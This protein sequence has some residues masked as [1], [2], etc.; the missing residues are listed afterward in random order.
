MFGS[1][2]GTAMGFAQ[3]LGK[4]ARKKNIKA[5]VV[6]LEEFQPADMLS[7][8]SEV[9]VFV[10]ATFGQGEGTDNAK[11]FFEWLKAN[12]REDDKSRFSPLRFAVFGLGMSQTYPARYQAAAK[13]VEKRMLELGAQEI[14]ERGEGDDNGD[15]ETNFEEWVD[16]LFPKLQELDDTSPA[17]E[18]KDVGAR[19]ATATAVEEEK[20]FSLKVLPRTDVKQL[21]ASRPFDPTRAVDIR[22]PYPAPLLRKVELHTQTSTRS[23]KH[24]ELDISDA[25]NM[26]YLTGDYLGVFPRNHPELVAQYAERLGLPLD[27]VMD[28]NVRPDT[29]VTLP[30]VTPCT[31]DTYLAHYAD[32]SAPLKKAHLSSL[33]PFVARPAEKEQLESVIAD[34]EVVKRMVDEEQILL[35]VMNRYASIDVPLGGFVEL[36][37]PL[38]PRYYSIS[39]SDRVHPQHIHLTVGLTQHKTR[40][41]RLHRGV[42]SDYLCNRGE[43]GDR[44]P[45]FV[46]NS[47]FKLPDSSHPIVMIAAGTG[48]APFRAFVQD[49]TYLHDHEGKM[50]GGTVLYFGCYHQDQDFLYRDELAKEIDRGNLQLVTAFSHAQEERVFVQ[51]KLMQNADRIWHLIHHEDANLYVCGATQMAMGVEDALVSIVEKCGKMERPLAEQYIRTLKEK[52]HYQEDKF[53]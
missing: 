6:D 24:I 14:V 21:A 38:Q 5:R 8:P 29:K 12:E 16:T 45:I 17:S 28:F 35:D 33:L 3:Q 42:C 13:W 22:N 1:Q 30:F 15:I 20:L 34:N 23:C 52:N 4:M 47:L 53:G 41:G 10:Q 39:S 7:K 44:V 37:P 48:L 2:T 49:R 11:S 9:Y 46:K 25:P 27:T 19:T 32:L 51:H 31:L 50:L 43:V 18:N 26:R 36:A 40:A